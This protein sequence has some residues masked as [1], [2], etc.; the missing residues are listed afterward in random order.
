MDAV[1]ERLDHGGLLVADG[2]GQ[3]EAEVF[4]M[5]DELGKTAVNGRGCKEPHVRAQVIPSLPV[6]LQGQ[7][8]LCTLDEQHAAREGL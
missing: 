5:V 7:V 2:I 1:A 3:A 4:R 8:H 6:E